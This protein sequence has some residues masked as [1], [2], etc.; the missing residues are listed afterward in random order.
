MQARCLLCLE[1]L[2]LPLGAGRHHLPRSSAQL[3]PPSP[4]ITGDQA[5]TGA[6]RPRG[7]LCT[8]HFL[9]K[10]SCAKVMLGRTLAPLH[11]L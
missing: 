2:A 3:P 10:A 4:F 8:F 1:H 7:H 5:R 11:L 9:R 6:G